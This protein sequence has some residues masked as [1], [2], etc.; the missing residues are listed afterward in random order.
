MPIKP[1]DF[2]TLALALRSVVVNHKVPPD[3]RASL[4]ED[5]VF[6]FAVFID[7]RTGTDFHESVL[8]VLGK[9]AKQLGAEP[10]P[11][12]YLVAE[13]EIVFNKGRKAELNVLR[14]SLLKPSV[15]RLDVEVAL[16]V[17]DV[18]EIRTRIDTDRRFADLMRKKGGIK[19]LRFSAAGNIP[20]PSW[21][22][23]PLQGSPYGTF[24]QSLG[25][26]VACIKKVAAAWL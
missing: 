19:A 11:T 24:E 12:D 1:N 16:G 17:R 5:V 13:L 7:E 6:H 20:K 9:H 21:Q 25:G 15:L 18:S 8:G 3:L 2:A 26:L 23:V 10:R 22:E 14:S 4:I